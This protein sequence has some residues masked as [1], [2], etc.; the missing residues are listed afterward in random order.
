MPRDSVGA[1]ARL[2]ENRDQPRRAA[3]GLARHGMPGLRG[4]APTGGGA[5]FGSM[6]PD[7]KA[8]S[9]SDE[10][11]A[12]LA[13]AMIE[14]PGTFNPNTRIPAGY[15]YFGQFVD[16]DLT[17]DPT[18]TLGRA[19][20][21]ADLFDFRTPRFDLDS[22]YGAG[23]M[24]QPYLYDW[25]PDG[26]RG[27]KLLVGHNPAGP[28]FAPEDLPR[29]DQGRA[30]IGDARNDE[31][32]IVSQLHLLFVRFHNKV[33]DHLVGERRTIGPRTLFQRAQQLVRWHYQWIVMHDW[34]PRIVGE[35][36][37]V[38]EPEHFTW[39]PSAGPFM[40]VEF[41]A[42][43]YR[44]GHSM[45]RDDYKPNGDHA[46]VPIAKSR[47]LYGPTL[48]G[49]RRVPASLQIDWRLF[50]YLDPGVFVQPSMRIDPSLTA[51][52]AALPPDDASLAF[53]NLRRGAALG[54]PAGG[55]VATALRARPLGEQELLDPLPASAG[56]AVRTVVVERT[57]LW[58][59]VLCEALAR[60][61]GRLLG[62]TGG[63]I[64]A[65]V[66]TG[67][68]RADP[69]SYVN[70]ETPWTPVLDRERE[71]RFTMADL[72]RFTLGPLRGSG[73]RRG[74]APA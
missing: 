68:L 37:A 65:E 47:V 52:L 35:D 32:L 7:L 21:P 25:S 40:P 19:N 1:G 60:E 71:D 63:R 44:F 73:S 16:H 24:A 12:A 13:A 31:N 11:A 67:L 27:V 70:A 5:R 17:F 42:A 22:L 58:Y 30:L 66:M 6:F 4:Q 59:Y 61:N 62:P 38:V 46:S 23:P 39:E 45:V 34:L 10:E 3:V 18:S 74:R 2:D 55:D 64:V 53:L 72:V 15:T 54:L 56:D 26:R 33:V 28:E 20:R 69:H 48:G 49:F 36:L 29:N 8:A 14:Q 43:A 9:L 41:S 50:Y 57:P 51:Q